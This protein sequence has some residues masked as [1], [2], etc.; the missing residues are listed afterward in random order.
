MSV[1]GKKN[2]DL[3]SIVKSDGTI[4]NFEEIAISTKTVIGISNLK[5]NLEKFYNY[6][7]ITDYT[8][9]QKKRGRKR[10]IQIATTSNNIPFGSIISIQRKKEVRGA[11]LKTKKKSSNISDE[12]DTPR[13]A[14]EKDYFLHSVSLVVVL[15]DNKQIN[16]KVSSNGKL[17]ITGCKC[18]D[19]FIQAVISVY[20]TM[21]EVEKWTGEILFTLNGDLEVVFNTVMQNMDFNVGFRINRY[22][23]DKYI[24]QYTNYC[25]IFEGSL[26]TGVNIKVRSDPD[27]YPKILKIR[28]SNGEL[29]R[30]YT[31]FEEYKTLLDKKKETKKDKHHTFLVFASGSIIMSSRGSEMKEVYD[32]LID[33]LTNNREHFEDKS[34]NYEKEKEED[35]KYSCKTRCCLKDDCDCEEECEDEEED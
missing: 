28:Y 4:K 1:D 24:N 7:P 9:P 26:S 17:Q 11:I 8:P 13:P 6:M 35:E 34:F 30:F 3:K 29:E 5:I 25:S 32:S 21:I 16:I 27:V 15:D 10:R 31:S 23:L 18:D 19:H 2:K 12:E 22:K 20:K 33:I 14:N